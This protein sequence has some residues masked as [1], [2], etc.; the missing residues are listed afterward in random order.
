MPRSLA[1]GL[2]GCVQT[3][4]EL[5]RVDVVGLGD[6]AELVAA[7]SGD[8]VGLAEGRP[9]RAGDGDQHVV[10]ALVPVGVVERLEPVDVAV[11]AR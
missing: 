9:Q 3:L 5:R 8:Q 7:E 4:A 10:A 1:G 2:D 6:H 11:D